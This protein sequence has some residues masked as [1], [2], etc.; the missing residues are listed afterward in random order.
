ME[1]FDTAVDA[2]DELLLVIGS[3]SV[4][5]KDNTNFI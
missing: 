2:A 3:A 4:V 5:M 1:A